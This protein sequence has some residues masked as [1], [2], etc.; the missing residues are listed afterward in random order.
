M[1]ISLNAAGVGVSVLLAV[2]CLAGKHVSGERALAKREAIGL[3]PLEAT[4]HGK[5]LKNSSLGFANVLA[6][7]LW[8]KLL[9]GA[10]HTPLAP[11]EVSWEFAQVDA[12]TTLDPNFIRAYDFGAIFLSVFRR[13]NLGAKIILEKWVKRS[14]IQWR[15][16]YLLGY[17]L[18]FEM[19]EYERASN[20][21]L[22]AGSLANAPP[23]LTA[24]GIRLMSHAGGLWQALRLAVELYDQIDDLESKSRLNRRIRALRYELQ[25]LAWVEALESFRKKRGREP[26]RTSDLT[27]ILVDN[28]REL[29]SLP[30]GEVSPELADLM[31]EPFHFSYDPAAKQIRSSR[32]REELGIDGVGIN[33]PPPT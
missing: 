13:D 33:R 31:S 2:V 3:K 21:L 8:V 6:D 22:K 25:R 1:K 30:L 24:L 14:P 28:N 18:Y 32:S 19:Q 23:Y 10:K 4:Y 26:A 9:Q 16:N 17:H 5:S 20:Y 7:I 12:I 27:P 15:P 29:A 11:G